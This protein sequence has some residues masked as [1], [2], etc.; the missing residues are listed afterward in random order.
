MSCLLH[1]Y[2][3]LQNVQVILYI[4]LGHL[5]QTNLLVFILEIYLHGIF[6]Q[7]LFTTFS[8]QTFSFVNVSGAIKFILP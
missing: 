2:K 6:L 7:D 5:A 3:I 4:L 1:L 8:P